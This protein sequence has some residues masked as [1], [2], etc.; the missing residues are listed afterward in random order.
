[1]LPL[2]KDEISLAALWPAL[3]INKNKAEHFPTK[4]NGQKFEILFSLVD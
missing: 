4:L 2:P 1:M 3:S